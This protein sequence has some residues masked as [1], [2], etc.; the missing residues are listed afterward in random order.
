[1][2]IRKILTVFYLSSVFSAIQFG[3]KGCRRASD[4]TYYFLLEQFWQV[5]KKI[6]KPIKITSFI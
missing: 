6:S 1:M 2:N 5:L 4:T 3:F